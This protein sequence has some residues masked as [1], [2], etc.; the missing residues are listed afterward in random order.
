SASASLPL[1]TNGNTTA[2]PAC[3]RSSGSS[4]SLSG[5]SMS[6]ASR[7]S[8]S[9]RSVVD[10]GRPSAI[11][12]S[13]A[14]PI[15]GTRYAPVRPSIPLNAS[16]SSIIGNLHVGLRSK[17]E[18]SDP[19]GAAHECRGAMRVRPGIDLLLAGAEDGA[20]VLSAVDGAAANAGPALEPRP[21]PEEL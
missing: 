2:Q 18:T 14:T 16:V 8:T 11:C 5:K 3:D 6:T 9:S 12:A 15:D 20:P 4:P 7:R 13:W 19:T 10:T 1:R 21:K 17:N